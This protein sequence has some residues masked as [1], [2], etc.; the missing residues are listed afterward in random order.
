MF[1]VLFPIVGIVIGIMLVS[2]NDQRGNNV[3][4]LSLLV[5]F[6]GIAYFVSQAGKPGY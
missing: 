3:L 2:R 5:G 6:L 1:A 4:I